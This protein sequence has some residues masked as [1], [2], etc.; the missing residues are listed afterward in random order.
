MRLRVAVAIRHGGGGQKP[1]VRSTG[2]GGRAARLLPSVRPWPGE[3]GMRVFLRLVPVEMPHGGPAG[4]RGAAVTL[5]PSFPITVLVR[6]GDGRL[7]R[8]GRR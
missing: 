4:I 7:C 1:L 5:L 6:A 8:A 3:T 2:A